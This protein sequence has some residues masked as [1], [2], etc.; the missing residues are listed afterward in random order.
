MKKG[1]GNRI[2]RI[3]KRDSTQLLARL[4]ETTQNKQICQIPLERHSD[5][6]VAPQATQV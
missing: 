1:R 5:M 4:V 3:H 6:K 2:K